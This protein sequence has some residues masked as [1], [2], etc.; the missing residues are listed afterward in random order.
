MLPNIEHPEFTISDTGDAQR[1]VDMLSARCARALQA[2]DP[3]HPIS[4]PM[5]VAFHY[6]DSLDGYVE[7]QVQYLRGWRLFFYFRKERKI[8]MEGEEEGGPS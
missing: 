4:C 2:D 7:S 1:V 6:D 5:F 3:L 8:V